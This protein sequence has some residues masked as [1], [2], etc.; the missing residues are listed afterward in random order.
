M[1]AAV[2]R[3]CTVTGHSWGV[4]ESRRIF[5]PLGLHDTFA[6]GDY[7]WLGG[8]PHAHSY[9]VVDGRPVDVT[10]LNSTIAGASGALVST[11]ADLDTFITALFDGRLLKPA[12]LT[13][14]THALPFT[15]NYGL[16]LNATTTSCGLTNWGHGGYIQGFTADLTST[17]DGAHRLEIYA[18]P[19]NYN[20][21][22]ATALQSL[23]NKAYCP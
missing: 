4:E 10:E 23:T 21:T 13:E 15:N 1:S 16:G 14:M 3:D 7:P 2:S 11:P 5:Q 9:L 18:T 20:A 12:Q 6:P 17:L 8:G 22:A 19:L